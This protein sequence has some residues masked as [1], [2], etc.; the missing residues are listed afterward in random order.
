VTITLACCEGR[1]TVPWSKATPLFHNLTGAQ[2]EIAGFPFG[3]IYERLMTE[4]VSRSGAFDLMA[5]SNMWVPSF[6]EGGFIEN[7]DPYIAKWDPD[8]DDIP[9]PV[10]NL[11]RLG[12][13]Y[14]SMQIDGDVF[15]LM[16]RE[17]LFGDQK[18][19]KEFKAR[20]GYDLHPPNTWDEYRDV[21]EFFTRD[22]DGDGEIDLWGNSLMCGRAHLPYTFVQ[23]MR[24]YGVPYFD[25]ETME[26][27]VNSPRAVEAL[28][29]LK[30]LLNY[31][32]PGNVA[33]DYTD[34]REAFMNGS[35]A[36]HINWN[37]LT[38]ERLDTS[39]VRGIAGYTQVPGKMIGGKLN[40]VS[41]QAWGWT[42][43]ISADSRNKEAAYQFLRF[44]TSPQVQANIFHYQ[45]GGYEP[46]RIS[47]FSHPILM[48][49]LPAAAKWLRALAEAME[50]GT[51]DLIIP[52]GFDYYDQIAIHAGEALA[53]NVSA[54][55]ALDACAKEWDRITKRRGKENQLASYQAL[56]E[57]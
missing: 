49:E 2:V 20:F 51:P 48:G 21:A 14:W 15:L 19:Q 52:G 36:M 50:I 40:Q 57:E 26:P 43:F 35:A 10:K 37:E 30:E 16:Y 7:L 54:Q 25:A 24:S 22:T 3:S 11:L 55:E 17:D 34:A 56:I 8:L 29:M 44:A 38:Y 45:T 39:A 53:G 42:V 18:Y 41:L 1:H 9:Q 5:V 13:S 33:W 23:M 31:M 4:A 6:K 47:E 27:Q 12:G 46:W 28:E 32:P